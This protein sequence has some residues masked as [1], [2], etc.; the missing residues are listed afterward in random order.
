MRAGQ[1]GMSGV[2]RATAPSRLTERVQL[3]VYGALGEVVRILLASLVQLPS[4]EVII[5]DNLYY[6]LLFAMVSI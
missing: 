5:T 6:T 3:R 1:T 2:L 4:G